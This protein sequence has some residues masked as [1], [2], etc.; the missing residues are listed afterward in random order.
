MGRLSLL[1]TDVF[2]GGYAVGGS[3]YG[4]SNTGI[5]LE[6]VRC[7]SFE[8]SLE[9]CSRSPFYNFTQPQCLNAATN[10]AGVLCRISGK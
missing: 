6:D 1:T 4:Y 2:I 8:S 10:S 7:S 9:G 3:V 5:V